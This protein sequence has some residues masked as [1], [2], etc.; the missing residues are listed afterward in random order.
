MNIL[1]NITRDMHIPDLIGLGG[2]L[3]V[4]IAYVL[5]SIH[6]MSARSYRYFGLNALGSFMIIYS[7]F[8][9]WNLSAF[10]MEFCWFLVSL[11]GVFS[12]WREVRKVKVG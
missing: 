9:Q 11:Y 10:M 2:V 12:V 1:M 3:I 8:Y 5:L 6:K 4:L 7:L